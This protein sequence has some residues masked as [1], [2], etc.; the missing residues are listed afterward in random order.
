M[1]GRGRQLGTYRLVR[2]LVGQK[3]ILKAPDLGREALGRSEI[4]AKTY[5]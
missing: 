4:S 5:E 3:G 1:V 2:A